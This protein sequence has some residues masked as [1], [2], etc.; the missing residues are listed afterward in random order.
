MWIKFTILAF[1]IGF[2]IVPFIKYLREKRFCK[3]FEA[4]ALIFSGVGVATL[5][6]I[7]YFGWN[8][9]IGD[10][11]RVY[12]H[13][14]IFLYSVREGKTENILLKVAKCVVWMY[15]R[16][17][18]IAITHGLSIIVL[19]KLHLKEVSFH[20]LA[21]YVAAVFFIFGFGSK[22]EYYSFDMWAFSVFALLPLCALFKRVCLQKSWLL[23]C[24]FFP[25][26][27]RSSLL[28]TKR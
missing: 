21:M 9:A 14:N 23:L 20:I 6:H 5:P 8:R 18:F 11:L 26:F 1:Y 3:V 24:F 2:A 19:C 4:V 28:Q 17:P 15:I 12:I 7:L 25:R 10:W 13:D 22:Y 16:N 27:C